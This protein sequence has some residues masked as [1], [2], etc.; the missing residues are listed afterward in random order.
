MKLTIGEN[1]RTLRRA[2]DMTQEQLA[3]MLGV[4][5]QSVSRWE[6]AQAYPDIE[7]IP[8]ITAIFETSTDVLM[9]LPETE[10]EKQAEKL[11]D[12]FCIATYEKPADFEKL[13]SMLKEIRRDFANSKSCWKILFHADRAA[14]CSPELLPEVRLFA[15]KHL[16][17]D[18]KDIDFIGTMAYVE[19]EEHI[20]AFLEKYTYSVDI[21]RNVI[22]RDR[23]RPQ[24]KLDKSEPLNQYI[25]FRYIDR[26]LDN[27]FIDFRDAPNAQDSLAANTF[28]LG[29]INSYCCQTPDPEHPIS[30]NGEVDVLVEHRISLGV[31]RAC[32]L[33]ATGDTEGAFKVL[34]DTV[35][36]LEKAMAITSPV[37]LKCASPWAKDISY[38][39]EE[40]WHNNDPTVDEEKMLYIHTRIGN[41]DNVYCV[42]PSMYLD[43]LTT[44]RGW[45]WFDPIRND[46][47]YQGYVDRVR[48]LVVT[49]PAK[50]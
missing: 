30:V 6:N 18:P 1:I 20:D 34:E 45:Q 43:W 28:K 16:D 33:S 22:L 40:D 49:R 23:Y 29:L 31:H 39:A 38:T 4:T 7:L 48:A 9:G 32:F 19:D 26:I 35:S 11:I 50:C 13:C 24:N 5:Y 46:P 15:E 14:L 21:P 2:K 47:R 27:G 36:L 8:A 25:N 42:Y 10:K 37:T 44:T 3:D 12:E 17:A 41:V